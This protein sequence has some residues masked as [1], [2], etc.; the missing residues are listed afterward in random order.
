[1]RT[2]DLREAA[3][4][5]GLHPNTLQARAKAGLVPGAKIGKEW[6]FLDLD[7]AEHLRR[8]YPANQLKEEMPCRSTKS[9]K[10]GTSHHP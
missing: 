9:R 4:F 8:Q 2:L 10:R 1:M 3:G 5:L 7:L 6:R